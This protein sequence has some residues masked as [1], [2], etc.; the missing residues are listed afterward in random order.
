MNANIG[1][2]L[3]VHGNVVGQADRQGE[4]IEVRGPGGRP[5]YLVRFDD[6]HQTL[7]YPGPDAVVESA[8]RT[9]GADG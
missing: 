1:D 8:R 7:V 5:P 4:I 2:R 9:E 6:G 3:H